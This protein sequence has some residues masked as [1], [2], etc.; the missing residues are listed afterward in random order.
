MTDDTHEHFSWRLQGAVYGTAFFYGTVNSMA[1]MIVALLV[2]GLISTE[3][4]FLIALVIASRQILTVTMSIYGGALMDRFGTRRVAISFGL[5]GVVAALIYPLLSGAFGPEMGGGRTTG[6][7]W[8]FIGAIIALQMVSGY[9]EATTWIG[10]QTMVGQLLKGHPLYAGRMT[11]TARI[12]G[13]IGPIVIGGAWD[14]WGAWGGFGF[15]S[16]WI[17]CGVGV[18]LFL[19]EGAGGATGKKDAEATG[20]ANATDSMPK[21][22]EYATTLRMLLVPAVAM[23]IMITMMRQTGSGVQSS[24]YVVWLDKEIGLSGTLIGI[25]LG[26]GNAA[27]AASALLT[28][29]LAQRF[30]SHWLLIVT[31]ALSI[32]GIAVTP[33]LGDFF[34]LLLIAMCARGIGQ[35]LNLPLMISIIAR[36]VAPAL[37]GRVTAM[38]ISFNRLGGA[39]VPLVMGALAE[40][41]G[42]A[43]AFYIIGAAGIAMLVPLSIWVA[44]SPSFRRD[45]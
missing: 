45:E 13:I 39:V 41:V 24:F 34:V 18:S 1:T 7:P 28:G 14:V 22:S 3:L 25:L 29:P 12:G 5:M 16:F 35:G 17:L 30:A 9:A 26:A 23:V 15:L 19:P 21:A 20:P 42:I 38:R 44:M 43:N 37:I 40:V 10:S 32:V 33:A 11:F 4:P 2:A 27:S 8:L 31:I 6:P 36:N